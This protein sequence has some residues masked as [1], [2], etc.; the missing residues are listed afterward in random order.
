M[1]FKQLYV[2]KE[3]RSFCTINPEKASKGC[4]NCKGKMVYVPVSI[5]KY[6]QMT[7]QERENFQAE[8]LENNNL[9]QVTI[10]AFPHVEE[11]ESSEAENR[12]FVSH[13]NGWVRG[14]KFAN[15]FTFVIF[16][17]AAIASFV[18]FIPNPL[19]AILVSGLIFCMGFLSIGMSM[20]F[21]NMAADI[22]AIRD[23]FDHQ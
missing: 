15:K 4:P 9:D 1:E 11:K 23:H 5:S 19:V 18:I 17:I 21:L 14:M 6:D 7:D 13:V 22:K 12:P 3:C 8:I 2:C 16:V 10:A 20:V